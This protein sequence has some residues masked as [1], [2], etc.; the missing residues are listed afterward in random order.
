MTMGDEKRS[1][2]N[3]A[4]NSEVAESELG[5]QLGKMQLLEG[6][7]TSIVEAIA[8][9]CSLKRVDRSEYLLHKGSQ[10]GHLFFLLSGR[11]QVV[12]VMEDGKEIGLNL[13][14]PGAYFGELAVIDDLPRSA[15]VRATEVSTVAMLP[16]RQAQQL[17]Y[18]NPLIAERIMK[19]MAASLRLASEYRAL[20]AIPGAVQ[21]VFALLLQLAKGGSSGSAV[22]ENL[23]KQK[24]I[25]IMVNTSRE[26]VSR[27][28][29]ELIQAGVVEKDVRRLIIRRPE[30]LM[31]IAAVTQSQVAE[32]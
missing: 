31:A 6:L 1:G 27:A 7:E 20:L 24:E 15:S 14:D 19:R 17:I 16:R 5:Q 12:D 25:A 2:E 26:T 8:S 23:P 9:G 11:L 21:R 22:I 3:V 28:I 29:Q 32:D 13:L 10:G 18:G 4:P 30:R